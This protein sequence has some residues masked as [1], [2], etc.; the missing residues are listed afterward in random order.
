MVLSS[1]CGSRIRVE[2]STGKSS[3][4]S[5]GPPPRSSA[6]RRAFDPNDRCFECGER[7]HYAYDCRKRQQGRTG[8]RR[9]SRSR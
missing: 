1:I 2:Y 8:G 4:Q 9:R 7:G 5:R 3:K 6:S